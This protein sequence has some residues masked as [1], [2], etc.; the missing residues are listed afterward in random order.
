MRSL[1]V[2]WDID[3]TL[4]DSGGASRRAYAAAFQRATGRTQEVPWQFDGRTE[5]AAATDVLRSH[6]VE[7]DAD[8]LATFLDLIVAEL[9]DR[10]GEMAAEGRVLP[11]VTAAL[12]AIDAWPHAYQSVLTGN[13]RPL[14]VLKL[15]V[16]ELS[17]HVNVQIG[18]Y[19]G[20]A[21]ERAD[22][23]PYAFERA[24]QLLGRRFTGADTVIIGD[25]IRDVVTAKQAGARAIG[26]ATGSFTP[27]ELRR[28]GAELVLGT[29]EEFPAWYQGIGG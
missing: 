29:L 6:G 5:L 3:H 16:F 11:G 14:A 19:G 24:E 22:L 21:Y 15:D 27:A 2:L 25:T 12:A 4:I 28:A 23:P 13:L 20:D 10:A 7:P 1:F 18:A 9:Q 8:L 26:V 17:R